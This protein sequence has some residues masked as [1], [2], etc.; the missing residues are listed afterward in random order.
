M[1]TPYGRGHDAPLRSLDQTD[2]AAL[3]GLIAMRRGHG[4]R[5]ALT[6]LA[7]GAL[8]QGLLHWRVRVEQHPLLAFGLLYGFPIGL[9]LLTSAWATFRYQQACRRAGLSDEAIANLRGH[10]GRVP[11]R[12]PPMPVDEMLGLVR[13]LESARQSAR[14]SARPPP[15]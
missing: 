11:A 7:V 15:R 13:A 2:D 10:L 9:M 5:V 3:R 6:A 12:L 4:L 14:Q 1:D 8:G